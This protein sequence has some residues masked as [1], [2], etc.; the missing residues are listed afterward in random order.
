MKGSDIALAYGLSLAACG[1]FSWYTGKRG[2]DL[3]KQSLGC[4][5]I[6]GTTIIA[7]GAV[8]SVTGKPPKT[9]AM[10]NGMFGLGKSKKGGVGKLNAKGVRLLETL[11]TDRLYAD[12]KNNGVKVAAIPS[13]PNVVTQDAD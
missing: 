2:S 10:N 11:D 5:A 1:A 8:V 4:A 9:V 7:I 13:N 6:T 12:M 3:V